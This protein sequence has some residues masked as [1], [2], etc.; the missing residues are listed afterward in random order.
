MSE[1]THE[2]RRILVVGMRPPRLPL[3]DG[4]VLHL[5]HLLAQLHLRHEVSFLTIDDQGMAFEDIAGLRVVMSAA[6]GLD[7]AIAAET[8]TFRPDVVHVVGAPL[9]K[10]LR[11][12]RGSVPTVLGALDAP[13]LNV[14]AVETRSLVEAM[15]KRAR[16]SRSLWVIRRQYG[17][18][19][20]VVVVSDEDR[21]ALGEVN[22]RLSVSVI[23]N[24]VDLDGFA[25]RD[26]IPREP[27]RLLFTGAL[28]YPPNVATAVFL[29]EEVMPTVRRARPDVRLS[30]VGRDPGERV[31]RLGDLEGVDVVGPVDDMGDALAVGSV[32]VCP[33]VSG[34]GIKNKLLEALANGLPCVASNLA[35]RGT[36]L[37]DEIDVLVAN[38]ADEVAARTLELLGD[39]SLRARLS[40]A[41]RHYVEDHHSWSSV[42]ARF[43]KVYDDLI[44][45]A[46]GP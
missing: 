29:A 39:E 32:Y 3:R 43:S 36:G 45:A 20:R 42:A 35:I 38:S 40:E 23:P 16:W 10:T 11:L 33:M 12:A 28:N 9:A 15:Q 27:G 25:P 24:G 14:D 2:R 21:A 19:D 8:L 46:E 17:L 4:Y 5:Y 41:G 30:L 6:A 1:T 34:T 13:H 26:R 37:T 31:R 44:N 22:A 18:A 7:S